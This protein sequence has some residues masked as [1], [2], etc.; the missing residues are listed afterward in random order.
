MLGKHNRAMRP[1]SERGKRKVEAVQMDHV[2][3]T[4]HLRPT[5]DSLWPQVVARRK[6]EIDHMRT[7]S[8]CGIDEW[9]FRPT[10][11]DG[12]GQALTYLF[13]RQVAD[14]SLDAANIPAPQ[15]MSDG[16]DWSGAHAR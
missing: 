14:K 9:P 16:R 4:E 8:F 12:H 13:A 2:R 5:P 1:A 3:L 7:P 10:E 15:Q 6:R 11:G